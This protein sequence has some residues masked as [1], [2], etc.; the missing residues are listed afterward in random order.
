MV[1][2]RAEQSHRSVPLC[3]KCT[4]AGPTWILVGR[5]VDVWYSRCFDVSYSS[6]SVG[7]LVYHAVGVGVLG[8]L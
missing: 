6:L 5:C 2:D 8:V 3:T 1:S 4:T 7:V